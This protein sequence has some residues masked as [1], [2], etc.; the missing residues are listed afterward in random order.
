MR[1]QATDAEGLE[2]DPLLLMHKLRE[3]GLAIKHSA[4]GVRQNAPGA[5]QVSL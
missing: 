2:T 5:N 4:L 1:G 3:E